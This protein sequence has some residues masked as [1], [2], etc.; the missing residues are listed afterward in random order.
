MDD[1]NI[2]STLKCKC[3][4]RYVYL[5]IHSY[6]SGISCKENTIYTSIHFWLSNKAKGKSVPNKKTTFIIQVYHVKPYA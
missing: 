2:L 3:N 6:I 1:K 4:E 5:H